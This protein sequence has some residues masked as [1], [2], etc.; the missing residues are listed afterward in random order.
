MSYQFATTSLIVAWQRI[1]TLSSSAQV[2]AG[3]LNSHSSSVSIVDS[4]LHLW[5]P[6]YNWTPLTTIRHP[7]LLLSNWKSQS[8]SMLCYDR[9]P[10]RRVSPDVKHPSRAQDKTFI[11]VRQ[12][13]VCCCGV[14]SLTRGRVCRLQLLLVLASAVILGSESRGTHGHNLLSQI[15]DCRNLEGYVPYLNPPETG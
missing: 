11:T 1:S 13:W 3:L 9:R 5:P 8:V 10:S 4:Q 12:L 6:N 7:W 2:V 14:P 15:R